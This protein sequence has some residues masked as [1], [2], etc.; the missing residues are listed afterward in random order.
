MW[1]LKEKLKGICFFMML[2]RVSVSNQEHLMVVSGEVIQIICF[3]KN[4]KII[5]GLILMI[6][7]FAPELP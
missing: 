6:N 4:M 7:P 2:D 1:H 5:L 3:L